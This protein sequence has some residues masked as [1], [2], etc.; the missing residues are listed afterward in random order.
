M[1]DQLPHTLQLDAEQ[2]DLIIMVDSLS[3]SPNQRITISAKPRRS[4][5]P[6]DHSC[7]IHPPIPAPVPVPDAIELPSGNA[8]VRAPES[9]SSTMLPSIPAINIHSAYS[10]TINH[11][12]QSQPIVAATPLSTMPPPT[13]PPPPPHS[14]NDATSHISLPSPSLS[15]ASSPSSTVKC[16]GRVNNRRCKKDVKCMPL[17]YIHPDDICPEEG[18]I[19]HY[20]SSHQV[21]EPEVF[22]ARGEAVKFSGA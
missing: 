10:V 7:E 20:C 14:L 4:S 1:V 17:S 15:S 6:H 11:Y 5:Y 13:S 12:P 2:K 9:V 19:P 3:I 22:Y 21:K 16:S 8:A 18:D